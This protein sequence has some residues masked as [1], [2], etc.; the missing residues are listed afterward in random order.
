MLPERY[1]VA[2]SVV[3]FI[4]AHNT[5]SKMTQSIQ[6]V[7]SLLQGPER[8]IL[9]IR[10]SEE[11]QRRG[12]AIHAIIPSMF[13]TIIDIVNICHGNN[14]DDLRSCKSKK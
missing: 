12:G 5:I 6:A 4:D 14:T 1:L 8:Y 2:S 3:T 9:V 11:K 7:S 13:S 10:D